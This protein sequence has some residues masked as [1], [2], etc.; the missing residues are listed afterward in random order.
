MNFEAAF[1][2]LALIVSGLFGLLWL[3]SPYLTHGILILLNVV[4]GTL[5]ATILL[6]AM[7]I[8]SPSRQDWLG[9]HLSVETFAPFYAPTMQAVLRRVMGWVGQVTEDGGTRG[10]PRLFAGSL[11]YRLMDRALLVAVLYP[12]MLIFLHWQWTGEDGRLGGMVVLEREERDWVRHLSFSIVAFAF[13]LVPIAG[14]VATRWSLPLRKFAERLQMAGD[15]LLSW[16]M[17]AVL[18]SVILIFAILIGFYFLLIMGIGFAIGLS[19]LFANVGVVDAARAFD[20]AFAFT[21]VVMFP[22]LVAFSFSI[23]GAVAGLLSVSVAIVI[24][25]AF[26]NPGSMIVFITMA[27]F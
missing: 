22:F 12:L 19:V 9:R 26:A 11:T 16:R 8:W 27:F 10:L 24:A 4:L 20:F 17:V 21:Y 14:S 23:S 2:V 15:R 7:T 5:A 13:F 25:V 1:A 3:F 6:A 18:F